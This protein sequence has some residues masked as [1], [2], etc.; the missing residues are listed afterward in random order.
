M[1]EGP[2]LAA[3]YIN[4]VIKSG[5]KGRSTNKDILHGYQLELPPN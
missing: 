4:I 2:N 3:N 1:I 5:R